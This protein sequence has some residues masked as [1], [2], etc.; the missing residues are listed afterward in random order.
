MGGR[1]SPLRVGGTMPVSVHLNHSISHGGV[2]AAAGHERFHRP[3]S[4]HPPPLAGFH[5]SPFR[6]TQG[7]N[8]PKSRLDGAGKSGCHGK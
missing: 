4:G 1:D 6:Q 3:V 8:A 7:M 2:F 5:T